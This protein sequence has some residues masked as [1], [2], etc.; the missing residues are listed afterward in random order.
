MT[1]KVEA[2]IKPELLVWARN[3]AGLSI[4]EVAKKA[5]VK[6]ARLEAW[7]SG[8]KRPSIPQLRKLCVI[9]KRP[10]AVF[11]LPDPPKT[12]TVMRDFR[13]L[14][15]EIAGIESP[16]LRWEI[17]RAEYRRD[18]ALDLFQDLEGVVPEFIAA[19]GTEEDP[20]NLGNRTR[21][22]LG[23][24]YE[25]QILWS[26]GYDAFAR[27][28]AAIEAQGVL[29]FQATEVSLDET[30][31]FSIYKAPLP[32]IVVN[33]KDAINGRIFTLLHE[34]THILLKE[35]GLCDLIEGAPRPPEEERMEVYCNRVSGA[36]LVPRDQLLRE[37]I[38]ETIRKRQ[39]PSDEDIG[40]LARRYYVSRE[41]IL[42]RLLIFDRITS[43]FYAA[44]REQYRTERERQ[45]KRE[46][47]FAP[48][49]QMALSSVGHTFARL[50]LAGY[51]Q[52]KITASDL[53]DFLELRLKHVPRF[54]EKV[55]RRMAR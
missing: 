32:V 39:G 45:E 51:H 25:D 31:G 48:P 36:A 38:V 37:E 40:T 27:W 13:R 29:V 53:S 1:R 7:E 42:R 21:E 2:I 55:I 24:K 16:A 41:T 17:R 46:G 3:S 14:P 20:E 5:K 8:A 35:G 9:Y 23:L 26:G 22:I 52:D 44:K 10:L 15:G 4:E 47:G 19:A 6:P 18:V 49:D 54:E 33:I 12:F 43:G 11:Y 50:V 28:R 30:R 34:F